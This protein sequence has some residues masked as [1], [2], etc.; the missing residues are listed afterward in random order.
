[1]A[2]E[3]TDDR[4][5]HDDLRRIRVD[6][7]RRIEELGISGIQDLHEICRRIGVIRGR[8]ITL[9]PI[10]MKAAQPC[11][12][13]VALESEEII[14]YDA[15]TTRAHQEHIIRHEL[16]HIICCHRGAG[17]LDDESARILFPNLEPQIVRDMLQRATY[18][19]AQEQEAEMIAFLLWQSSHDDGKAR[20]TSQ[21]ESS[22]DRLGRILM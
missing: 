9:I 7:A 14:F 17:I 6:G 8:P 15:N 20:S 1:M 11:G 2:D 3:G 21:G 4:Q 13:W 18:D 19:D 22:I 12:I 10:P 16:G 5:R